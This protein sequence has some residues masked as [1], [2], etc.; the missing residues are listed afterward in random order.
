MSAQPLT[1]ALLCQHTIEAQTKRL[2]QCHVAHA[3]LGIPNRE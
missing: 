1:L 2:G 3:R